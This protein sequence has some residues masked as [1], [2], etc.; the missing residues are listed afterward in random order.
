[1]KKPKEFKRWSISESDLSD[2]TPS[3]ARDLI[4][5]C[6][7]E[8]QKET[9]LRSRQQLGIRSSDEDIH[10]SVVSGVRLAF[11]EADGDFDKPTKESLM[12]VVGVLAKKSASW[13][14]PEDIIEHHKKQIQKVLERL[15]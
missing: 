13:G 6:F 14:T 7:Y 5:K 3:K 9:F 12:N 11:K 10:A 8:A 4:V 15:K 1:M 2:L